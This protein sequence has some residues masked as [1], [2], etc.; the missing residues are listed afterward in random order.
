MDEQFRVP[1]DAL[2]FLEILGKDQQT[3]RIRM[4]ANEKSDFRGARKDIFCPSVLEEWMDMRSGIYVVVNDGGDDDSS[5]NSCRALFVEHDDIPLEEQLQSWKGVLP[6]PTMQIYTGGKSYHQYWV[7]S[8]PIPV[9]RWKNLTLKAIHALKSDPQVKNPSRVMRLPGFKYYNREGAVGAIASIHHYS[10]RKYSAEELEAALAEVQI[11]QTVRSYSTPK[12]SSNYDWMPARP[13]P[14][15]GR[16]RD[17]K[18]RYSVDKNYIQCHIGDTFAPPVTRGI[19]IKG[20]DGKQWKK[21][22]NVTN[23]YGD[24]IGFTLVLDKSSGVYMK[25]KADLIKFVEKTYGNRLS[26]NEL[27]ERLELDGLPIKDI[28]LMH[29]ELARNHDVCHTAANVKDSFLW[30]GKKNSYNP[31][32]SFLEAAEKYAPTCAFD[33]IGKRYLCLANPIESRVF[34]IHLL[35]A[36]YRAFKPGYQYDQILIMRGPQGVGKTRSIKALSGSPEHYMSTTLI[37]QEKDFLIQLRSCWHCELE[38]IDGHIDSKHEAHLKALISRHA[39]N[40]RPLYV[41]T[42]EDHPRRCV[43]W[44]TTNQDKLLVDSTGNRRMM[45]IDLKQSINH[46]ELTKNLHGIWAAVMK[47]YR[48]GIEPLLT[49]D[50]IQQM[51]DVAQ[52]SFK[53]DPW[54]GIIEASIEETP[55]VFE[56]DILKSTLGMEVRHIKGGRS[57]DQR[58]VRDCLSQLGYQRYANQINGLNKLNKGYG[59]RTR[60]AWFAPGV[61]P[62]ANGQKVKELL[63][64]AG[65]ELPVGPG[66]DKSKDAFPGATSPIF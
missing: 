45:I 49:N 19:P 61:E 14:I 11:L 38:E 54:L 27:K 66:Y 10:E 13:C 25:S 12:S 31:V 9:E 52:A 18:C 3:T 1:T 5:I 40:Y 55:V 44:G 59:D 7:F 4:I 17:D 56:H 41:P 34:G 16:D 51:A 39:D 29:C 24:A 23:A 57:G 15:C 37:Q 32:I 28:D 35:A 43:F 60:G 53:E 20:H 33:D 2:R 47:A 6:E 48:A 65:K 26:Y 36:V 58:R 63:Q 46:E 22:R 62:T 50:E 21:H 64:E 42:A 8:E 30:V